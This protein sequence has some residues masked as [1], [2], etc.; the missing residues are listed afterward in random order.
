M[1]SPKISR[2]FS[3]IWAIALGIPLLALPAE[4]AEQIV[5]KYS[6][7]RRS[8]S[9]AELTIFAETGEPSP[10]LE[11]ILAKTGQDPAAVREVL[12]RAIAVDLLL[13]DR[14]V[15][16]PLGNIVLDRVAEI[17]HTPSGNTNRQALRAALILSASDDGKITLLET[18]QNYPTREVEVEIDRLQ[19]AYRQLN[20]LLILLPK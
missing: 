17:I 4:S 7:F 1:I 8:L 14:I 18:L 2:E 9:V 16:S 13:L 20:W 10:S 3:L 5:L 11:R 15:N 6:I 12:T 19:E